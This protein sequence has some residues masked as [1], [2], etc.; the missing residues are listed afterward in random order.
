MHVILLTIFVGLVLVSLFVFL[1]LHYG[2][3]S[4]GGSDEHSAL[5]PLQEEETRPHHS[6]SK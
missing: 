4:P 2:T 5:L 3:R 1:F 6:R